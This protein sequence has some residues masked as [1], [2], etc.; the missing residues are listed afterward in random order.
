LKGNYPKWFKFVGWHPHCRCHIED[1]LASEEEF[2]NHQK[3]I[4]AGEDVE[5]KSKNEVSTLPE[6]FTG[7]VSDNEE[8]ITNATKN[9]TLPY[10]LKDNAKHLN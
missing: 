6:G 5:L 9:G 1:I 7:W 10:F 8:R 4:L 2:I 3:R